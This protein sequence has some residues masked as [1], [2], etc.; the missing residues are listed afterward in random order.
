MNVYYLP[1]RTPERPETVPATTRWSMGHARAHR[2]WWRVRLTASDVWAAVRRGGRTPLDEHVWF[3]E[4]P[5][6]A[7]R[8]RVVGPARVL[9]LDDARRRR[10]LAAAAA[11][12]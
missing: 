8:R 5:P 4:G 6:V 2:F 10:Q 11:G 9:H 3:A 7:P 1:S 12:V